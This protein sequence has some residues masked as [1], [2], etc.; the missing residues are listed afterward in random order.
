MKAKE[1]NQETIKRLFSYDKEGFLVWNKLG[2]THKQE[3]QRAGS[4]QESGYYRA[5]VMG[6][7]ANV[8]RLI[9]VYHNGD[10]PSDVQIDHIDRNKSNNKI[11]NLRAVSA[12]ENQW[13]KDLSKVKGYSY[14]KRDKSYQARIKVNGKLIVLGCF[15][16]EEDA[17]EAYVNAK[18][19]LHQ[20]QE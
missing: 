11:E 18:A 15:K 2:R 14:S 8:H 7:T 5:T 20:I 6:R 3:G 9:Y 10:I 12:S 13:N 19:K 17:R 4:K 1:I 16:K